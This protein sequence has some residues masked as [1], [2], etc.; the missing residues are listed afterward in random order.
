MRREI[1]INKDN[2][3]RV[4][5]TR[6]L[7]KEERQHVSAFRAYK[8]EDGR[9]ILEP[10]VE[11]KAK[12]HWIYKNPEALASLMRGLEDAKEGRITTLD[13]DYSQFLD[14]EDEI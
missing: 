4:S 10:L 13:I 14:E 9:I 2:L 11:V 3:H 1:K 5:L 6:L 8:E 7:S 12:D